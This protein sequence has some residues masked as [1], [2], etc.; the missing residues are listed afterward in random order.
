MISE[1]EGPPVPQNGAGLARQ[2]LHRERA[3]KEQQKK[4]LEIETDGTV[5]GNTGEAVFAL[6]K[7][8]QGG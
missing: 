2:Q 6:S 3:V 1:F 5:I 7:D 8:S 4:Q